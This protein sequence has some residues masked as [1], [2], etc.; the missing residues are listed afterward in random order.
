MTK[1][2]TALALVLLLAAALF[3]GCG[4]GEA[5]HIG[6]GVD[7]GVLKIVCTTFPQ[8]DWT[9]QILG[10]KLADA[11]VTYLQDS[12]ADLHSY[13]ATASDFVKIQEADLF[14]YVGGESDDWVPKALRDA[15]YAETLDLL[16]ALG[17]NAKLEEA[18]EGAEEEEEEEEEAYDEHVWLSLKNAVILV[19]AL[20]EKIAALDPENAEAYKANAAAYVKELEALDAEYAAAT[21]KAKIHTLLF[22]DRFPFRYLCDDYKIKAF[23]AFNGCSAETE[24]S[25]ET[26]ATLVKALDDNNLPAVAVTESSDMKIA[27]TLFENATVNKT[28]TIVVM[29][30]LQ[31][32]TGDK[33]EK[34]VTYLGV[35]RE[36]L[37]SLKAALGMGT[38]ENGTVD[39]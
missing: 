21:S 24:V 2:I 28:Q 18:V 27:K 4:G 16:T 3:A 33:A 12:G 31:S 35:M 1:K 9:R 23:A 39:M 32:V 10:D 19:N 36:N 6:G 30:S 11:E 17:E 38:N 37:T 8:Y 7:D 29:N 15:P 5:E 22:A 25:T 14:V 34:G 13:Q 20:A 26:I